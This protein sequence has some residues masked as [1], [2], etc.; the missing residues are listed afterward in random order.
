MKSK[1]ERYKIVYDILSSVCFTKAGIY[2]ILG[3]MECESNVEACR[4]QGDFTN[5]RIHSINYVSDLRSGKISRHDFMYDKIGF[6]LCQWTYPVWK[7]EL[8]DFGLNALDSEELQ[9]NFLVQQLFNWSEFSDLMYTLKYCDDIYTC[10]KAFLEMYEKP[11]VLNIDSRYNAALSA[12]DLIE[13]SSS[14]LTSGYQIP[15]T[16]TLIFDG[17]KVNYRVSDA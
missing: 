15:D 14:A 9:T 8:F 7:R 12:R 17:R 2:G 1:I 6:G 5:S 11:A 16:V 13:G 10:T 3:N 4:K